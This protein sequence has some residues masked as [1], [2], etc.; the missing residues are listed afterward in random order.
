VDGVSVANVYE[1]ALGFVT[2]VSEAVDCFVENVLG[3]VG[4]EKDG[5]FCGCGGDC[6]A[7]STGSDDDG[8]GLWGLGVG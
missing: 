2:L 7:D 1:A 3:C 4:E 8:Y 5:F 6:L